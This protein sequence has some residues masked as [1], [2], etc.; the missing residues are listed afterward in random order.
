MAFSRLTKTVAGALLLLLL[1]A[2][3]ESDNADG[4]SDANNAGTRGDGGAASTWMKRSCELPVRYLELIRRGD[5]PGRSPDI[6]VVHAAPNFFGSFAVTSHSGPWRYLQKVPL[7]FYG[8][9]FIRSQGE[10]SLDR[11][12][13][14]ADLAPTLADLLDV[15]WPDD[16]EG[17]AL[18]EVLVPR[19]ER[20][21]RPKMILVVVWDGGGWNVLTRWPGA[22]HQVRNLMKEGTSV[23]GTSVG[24]SPSVTPAIHAS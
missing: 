3:C 11:E 21:G 16:R 23:A 2:A 12:V 9:G 8:P 17:R 10:I 20:P 18:E 4:R 14:V 7:L 24:S 19:E 5:F 13:T 22:W 15:E 6:A 1:T